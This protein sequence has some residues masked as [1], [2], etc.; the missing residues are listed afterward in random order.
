MGDVYNLLRRIGNK[1][2][3]LADAG[4]KLSSDLIKW[5]GLH[6]KCPSDLGA[7]AIV[8]NLALEWCSKNEKHEK[9]MIFLVR[10]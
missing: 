5:Y 4:D 6:H 1:V 9:P 3:A 8:T 7:R 2:K 10:E